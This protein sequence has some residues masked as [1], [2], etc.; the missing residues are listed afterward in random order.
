MRRVVTERHDSFDRALSGA[1][2]TW[3]I[4]PNQNINPYPNK[5]A[6][7]IGAYY[8]GNDDIRGLATEAE[9]IDAVRKAYHE[10]GEGAPTH[11]RMTLTS[12]DPAGVINS[13]MAVLPET[14]VMGGYMY[15]AGFADADARFVTPIFDT[16][17]GAPLA[18]VDGS[19]VNTH[20]T[21]AAGAVAVDALAQTDASSVGIIGSGA[22]A[23]G[24]LRATVEVRDI[25]EVQVFSP[26]TAHRET[27]AEEMSEQ[28]DTEVKPVAN[29]A[30]AA[31]GAD[32]LITATNASKPVVADSEIDDGTHIN[33]IG[34]YDPEKRELESETVRRS[35]YVPDLRAR[36]LQDAGAFL[37]A[38][39]EGVID[40][41]HIHAELGEVVAGERPGRITDEQVT[42]FDS[43][44]TALETLSAAALLARRAI[45][46]GN[47][48]KITLASA[49]EVYTGK[50]ADTSEEL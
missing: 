19:Y 5:S 49:S 13:Y 12:D 47:G 3:P 2:E 31:S 45:A 48:A 21:G 42:V 36:A 35:V 43:G 40:D 25:E 11:P 16:E 27:F 37:Q 20:K 24:Q 10:H 30:T 50:Q 39:D 17:S 41:G 9:F 6:C 29:S 33:A 4:Y 44:G 8:L 28:L 15:T 14:G 46:E 18:V 32:I 1:A 26:T 38:R 23:R 7:V 22:Q 34:Q